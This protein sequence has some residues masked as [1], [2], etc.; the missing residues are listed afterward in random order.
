MRTFILFMLNYPN[1]LRKLREEMDNVVGM[2]RMPDW[3]DEPELP[4][5]TACI[6]ESMRCRPAIPMVR[7][8]T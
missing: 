3:D 1:I 6:K 4:Y 8:L 5:L 7:K 2:D